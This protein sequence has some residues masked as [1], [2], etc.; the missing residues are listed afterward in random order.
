MLLTLGSFIH[1]VDGVLGFFSSRPKWDSPTPSTAGEC[2]PPRFRGGA[3]SLAGEGLGGGGGPNSDE[4]TDT[5][6]I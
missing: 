1:G 6:V 5:V 2:V 4:V 3:R